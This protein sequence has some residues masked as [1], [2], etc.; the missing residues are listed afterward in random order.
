[1]RGK[2]SSYDN[3]TLLAL[4]LLVIAAILFAGP[5]ATVMAEDN[6]DAAVADKDRAPP[7]SL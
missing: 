4:L 1:M 7:P 2:N 6:P 5:L 3:V